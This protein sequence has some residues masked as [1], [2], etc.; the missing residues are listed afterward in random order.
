MRTVDHPPVVYKTAVSLDIQSDWAEFNLLTPSAVILLDPA[1]SHPSTNA[2][3]TRVQ[4]G[5]EY[6]HNYQRQT[7]RFF[8][9]NDGSPI[10]FSISRG[11]LAGPWTPGKVIV[12][13]EGDYYINDVNTDNKWNTKWF[14]KAPVTSTP[15]A[16]LANSGRVSEPIYNWTD[17]LKDYLSESETSAK[18]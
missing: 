13:I 8:V 14:D 10:N 5:K 12:T 17:V 1:N 18:A 7:L 11:S 6:S 4:W 16:R 9:V 15:V 3:D 2:V